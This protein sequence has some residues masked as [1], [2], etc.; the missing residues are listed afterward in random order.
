VL[1][2]YPGD[3]DDCAVRRTADT[4]VRP[5]RVD[6]RLSGCTAV[7]AP[8]GRARGAT[9]QLILDLARVAPSSWRA[10]P[11]AWVS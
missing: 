4:K 9:T 11:R 10:R 8:P 6:V 3:G 7:S 5:Q 1:L 2:C